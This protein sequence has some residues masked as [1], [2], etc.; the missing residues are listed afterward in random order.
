M[1]DFAVTCPL[2][3]NAPHL[4]SGSCTSP[5]TFGLG[6]LQ[7]PPHDDALALLLAFGSSFTWHR[8]FH[9]TSSVPCLA[10]TLGFRRAPLAARRPASRCSVARGRNLS[11]ARDCNRPRPVDHS[12]TRSARKSMD[13]GIAIASALAA[14]LLTRSSNLAGSSTGRSAGFAPLRIFPARAPTRRVRAL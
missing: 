3:P 7:T 12:I 2:V 10:H 13:G 14:P 6:F 8:D 11:T 4:R 1:E 5:R 9:P